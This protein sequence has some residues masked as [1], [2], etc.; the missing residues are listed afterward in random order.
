MKK[1]L[2]V[3]IFTML[4]IFFSR[5]VIVS[6]NAA[7]TPS[8]EIVAMASYDDG[9]TDKKF[10]EIDEKAAELDKKFKEIEEREAELEKRL[11]E[12]DNKYNN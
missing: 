5:P 8:M 9:D 6:A 1:S 7:A 4:V 10:E 3:I 2:T 11:K 12:I